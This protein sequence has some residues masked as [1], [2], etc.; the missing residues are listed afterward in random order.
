[1]L[2]CFSKG[3]IKLFLT[4]DT[5]VERQNEKTCLQQIIEPMCRKLR[6]KIQYRFYKTS[7]FMLTIETS[8]IH[9][10]VYIESDYI[11]L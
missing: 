1:M 3:Y 5:H 9:T 4:P 10:I 2:A 6:K 7:L 8:H 11:Q